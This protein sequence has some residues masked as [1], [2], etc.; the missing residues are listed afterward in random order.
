[1]KSIGL[2]IVML[3]CALALWFFMHA[4]PLT[5]SPS[6]TGATLTQDAINKAKTVKGMADHRDSE[7]EEMTQP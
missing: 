2:F 5:E 1:M 4:S 6:G 7:I 3:A